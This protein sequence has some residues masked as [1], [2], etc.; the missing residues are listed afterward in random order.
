M[1]LKKVFW[2]EDQCEDLD[3]YRS[4]L[5]REGM[6]LDIVKSISEAITKL[7][8]GKNSYIAFI[9]D[10]KVRPGKN[11]QWVD[12]D[13]TKR[14][15]NPDSDS[16]LGLELLYSLFKQEQT[17]VK[18]KPSIHIDPKKVIVFSAVNVH[19]LVDQ[20]SSM[21]IPANHV[22]SKSSKDAKT[23]LNMIQYIM[24]KTQG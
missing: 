5:F 12:L 11:K 16:Y 4:T 18:L 24:G 17:R 10:I 14:E 23:L 15:E 9:F 2:L 7:K 21:G 6:Q 1:G 3:L 20:V 19:E 22:L 13:K 8:E